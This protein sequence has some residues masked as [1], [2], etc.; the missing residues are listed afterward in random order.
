MH[1]S[2]HFSKNGNVF[3]A[4]LEKVLQFCKLKQTESIN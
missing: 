4:G 3:V 1:K 2:S